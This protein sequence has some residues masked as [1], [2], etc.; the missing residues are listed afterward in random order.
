MD[1]RHACRFR[2]SPV[3]YTPDPG[4]QTPVSPASLVHVLFVAV[5]VVIA[6]LRTNLATQLLQRR[7]GRPDGHRLVDLGGTNALLLGLGIEL[8]RAVAVLVV[9]DLP[10]WLGTSAHVLAL[11][12]LVASAVL[13]LPARR[14]MQEVL[15]QLDE[16]ERLLEGLVDGASDVFDSSSSTLAEAGLTA[17]EQEIIDLIGRGITTDREISS[18]LHISPATSGTHVRNILRKTGY[19][20]RRHLLLATLRQGNTIAS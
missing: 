15:D 10:G 1:P 12:A 11:L 16:N 2:L 3:S 6:G 14:A 19:S 13:T 17:R 20:S 8:A 5:L 18:L 4:V 7:S 9:G